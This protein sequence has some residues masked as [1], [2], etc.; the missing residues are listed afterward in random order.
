MIFSLLI[1]HN[2]TACLLSPGFYIPQLG[3]YF[4]ICFPDFSERRE[5]IMTD[6]NDFCARVL[7]LVAASSDDAV[8]NETFFFAMRCLLEILQKCFWKYFFCFCDYQCCRLA[9]ENPQKPYFWI[10]SSK[11]DIDDQIR[12]K[13]KKGIE[14]RVVSH[15][16]NP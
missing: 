1:I 3:D 6:I 14:G 5:A 15:C 16:L 2:H 8:V 12:A 7:V 10:C 4:T 11:S 9:D 13:F